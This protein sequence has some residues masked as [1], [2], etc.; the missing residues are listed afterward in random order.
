MS[1]IIEEEREQREKAPEVVKQESETPTPPPSTSPQGTRQ[2]STYARRRLPEL[3]SVIPSEPP[4][5]PSLF[6]T[7][8]NTSQTYT[9]PYGEVSKVQTTAGVQTGHKFPL[10]PLS[11]VPVKANSK[12]NSREKAYEHGT[13]PIVTQLTNLLMRDGKKSVAERNMATILTTLRTLPAPTKSTARPLLP[14][15][16][17]ASY[18]PLNPVAYLTAAVDGVAPLMR[19]RSQ[20]GAAGGGVALQIPV[21]LGLRQRRRTAFMWILDAASKRANRGSGKDMFAQRVANELVA[22]IE[23]RSSVWEKR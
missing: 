5:D 1:Q 23:G 11:S 14:G 12:K 4:M 15:T 16:P 17:D 22:V 9:N 19:I 3:Q 20:R 7:S 6:L 2:F 21:P 8:S 10:P 18:L 13:T